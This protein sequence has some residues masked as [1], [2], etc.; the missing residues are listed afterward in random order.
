MRTDLFLAVAY[1]AIVKASS[2]YDLTLFSEAGYKGEAIQAEPNQCMSF[3]K[4]NITRA[5]SVAL[6]GNHACMFFSSSSCD[7]MDLA[8][9]IMGD[10]PN[11][12][13]WGFP[14]GPRAV[15]CLSSSATDVLK[16]Y[17]CTFNAWCSV[18]EKQGLCPFDSSCTQYNPIEF[19]D[20]QRFTEPGVSPVIDRYLVN[21][22][23]AALN[24]PKEELKAARPAKIEVDSR[25][26]W[27]GGSDDYSANWIPPAHPD[28]ESK[29][30]AKAMA[31][32]AHK[33]AKQDRK[34]DRKDAR[35][36]NKEQKAYEKALFEKAEKARKEKKAKAKAKAKAVERIRNGGH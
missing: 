3:S 33:Q 26:N 18:L 35:R 15:K 6:A 36:K 28:P 14:Y 20:W 23:T 17:D 13:V 7:R 24:R 30:E 16:N 34:Q 29:A 4:H 22:T 9:P 10:V 32:E 12:D 19:Q 5:K 31:K 25:K 8:Q 21:S 27:E 2:D 11:T 1:A